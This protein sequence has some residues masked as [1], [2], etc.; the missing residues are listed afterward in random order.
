V[1]WRALI[2]TPHRTDTSFGSLPMPQAVHPEEQGGR[3]P[4]HID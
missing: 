4:P 2:T 1:K 3:Q